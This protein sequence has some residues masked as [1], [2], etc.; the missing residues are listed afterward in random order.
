VLVWCGRA[1]VA[2]V[3]L[4]SVLNWVG[5]ATGNH[6]LTGVLSPW[7]YMPPW[8]AVI[9]AALGVAILVQLGRPS[10]ARVRAGCGLAAVA[11]VLAAVF[12]AEHATGRPFGLD[13]V[14]FSD[15]VRAVQL[16]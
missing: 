8:S 5:W 14:S 4:F 2:V 9:Q 3:L 1:A 10:P 6:N 11:G 16:T 15:T 12:V 7:P 13:Q